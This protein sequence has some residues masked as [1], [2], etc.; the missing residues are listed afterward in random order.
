[1]VIIN[2]SPKPMVPATPVGETN[3][4]PTTD[5]SPNPIVPVN[6][7]FSYYSSSIAKAFPKA[8]VPALPVTENIPVPVTVTV[9][10]DPVA[11]AGVG[12]MSCPIEVATPPPNVITPSRA[13]PT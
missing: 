11:T 4:V 12:T 3:A 7:V 2:S 5:S 10:T 1:M 9:P 13:T 6:P 8:V